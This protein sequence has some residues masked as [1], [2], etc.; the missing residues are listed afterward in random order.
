ME[1]SLA[2]AH[3]C[4]TCGENG[5]WMRDWEML[6]HLAIRPEHQIVSGRVTN[7]RWEQIDG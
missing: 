1:Y 7:G 3:A 5:F 2:N 6:A 4:R